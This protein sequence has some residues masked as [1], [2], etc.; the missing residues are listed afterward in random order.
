MLQELGITDVGEIP[1]SPGDF[2]RVDQVMRGETGRGVPD[3]KSEAIPDGLGKAVRDIFER[4]SEK[5]FS[6]I[7]LIGF[8]VVFYAGN[9][10]TM[11]DFWRYARFLLVIPLFYSLLRFINRLADFCLNW[12]EEFLKER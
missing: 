3:T 10:R 9:I 7:A 12:F 5:L 11:D 4:H 6:A 1:Q 2:Q 8:V